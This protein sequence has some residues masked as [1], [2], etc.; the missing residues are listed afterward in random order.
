MAIS[1]KVERLPNS[2]AKLTLTISNEE[3]RS[4]YDALLAEYSGKIQIPG[5]RKGKAPKEVLIRKFGEDAFK[6]EVLG[7]TIDEALSGVLEDES[8]SR[9]NRPLPYSTPRIEDEQSLKLDLNADLVFSVS[10]D[11]MP[12]AEVETWKGLE[13][14]V[15][16]AEVGDE[17]VNRELEA[18]RERNAVV[19]DRDENAPAVKDD[20]V[21][22]NYAEL[23]DAGEIAAGSE[24]ED[25]VFTLG[26]GYN[27]YQ[28]DD[29]L[30]GMKKGET[31]DIEKQ[32]PPDFKDAGLAGKTKKIRVTLTA[33]KEKR[34]PDLDDELAQDVDEKFQTLEDL[35]ADIRARLNSALERRLRDITVSAILEKILETASMEIPESMIRTELDSR[36][37]GMARRMNTDAESLAKLIEGTKGSREALLEESRPAAVKALQSRLVVETLIQDLALEAGDEELEKEMET[38]ATETGSPL[39]DIKAYYAADQSREYLK[40]QIKERKLFDMLIRENTVKKGQK[41]SYLDL[42]PNNG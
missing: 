10:Y 7:R 35:K 36:W 14:E 11:V 16:G 2:S 34:L 27:V 39:E 3:V 4:R 32:F 37:R 8:F 21:T 1:K 31:K 6:G 28:F 30:T 13:V 20:V 12:R 17:D 9:E 18:I 24:R 33:L 15:P 19:L 41:K 26:S 5:F 42:I 38:I 29:E 22:V 40:E 25:F 23:N